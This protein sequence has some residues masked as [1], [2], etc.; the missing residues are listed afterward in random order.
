MRAVL[1]V[2]DPASPCTGVCR[3]DTGGTC[4]GCGRS[5]DEIAEW[6]WASAARRREI[7]AAARERLP[8]IGRTSERDPDAT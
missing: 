5:M 4:T 6:P 7:A 3:L 1:S 8:I 2:S